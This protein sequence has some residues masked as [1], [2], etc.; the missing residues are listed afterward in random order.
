MIQQ[1]LAWWF[2]KVRGWKTEGDFPYTLKK[3]VII[4]GPHT[5]NVDFLLG[6]A[7]RKKLHFEFVQFLGKKELFNPIT[8]WF[9]RLLGGHP[10]NRSKKSNMVDQV[11]ALYQ[12]HERFH[13]AL[14]P[15]G[16]RTKVYKFRTGFYHIAKN[17][18]VPILMVGFD[19]GKRRV[20]FADPIFPSDN[21]SADM[22]LIV[23]FFKQ[24]EGYVPA[25]GIT[26]DIVC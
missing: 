20:V 3:S 21:E 26:D 15:E 18:K 12:K 6:L 2:F 17:A 16:T 23:T 13:I 4:A 10:V 24:F 14:S 5:H 22:R 9:F 25:Y 8:G 19:F 1:I 11:V 7:V